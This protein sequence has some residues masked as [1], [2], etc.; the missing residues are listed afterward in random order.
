MGFL[1][2]LFDGAREQAQGT[3][4]GF[5]NSLEAK[6]RK[7]GMGG[8][9]GDALQASL[10]SSGYGSGVPSYGR[11]M[12][13]KR[14]YGSV[15]SWESAKRAQNYRTAKMNPYG[16]GMPG[17]MNQAQ[18]GL[19]DLGEQGMQSLMEMLGGGAPDGPPPGMAQGMQLDPA[20]MELLQM[21]QGGQGATRPP[22]SVAFGG[23]PG[24]AYR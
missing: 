19:G 20:M 16:A 1:Q 21:I 2:D 3:L 10:A 18:Q 17:L 23:M 5:G 8:S 22:A 9:L 15:D 14:A 11:P 6:Y 24:P 4:S 7:P 13:A 12:G